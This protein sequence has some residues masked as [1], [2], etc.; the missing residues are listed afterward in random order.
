MK[1]LCYT[2]HADPYLTSGCAS[3]TDRTAVG[4][5]AG[6]LGLVS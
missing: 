3:H 1:F 5:N 6:H 4:H 2:V